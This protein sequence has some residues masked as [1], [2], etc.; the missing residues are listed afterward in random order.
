M[1]RAQRTQRNLRVLDSCG[2]QAWVCTPGQTP[3]W[4]A[5]G[6]LFQ[7]PRGGPGSHTLALKGCLWSLL[8]R[9]KGGCRGLLCHGTH[10]AAAHPTARSSGYRIFWSLKVQLLGFRAMFIAA[11]LRFF[12]FL[13]GGSLTMPGRLLAIG[14]GPSISGQGPQGQVWGQMPSPAGWASS[15]SLQAPPPSIAVFTPGFWQKVKLH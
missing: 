13:T 1:L 12:P 5:P 11:V 10:P 9:P 14:F 7:Q 6:P 4:L 2:I 8:P 3:A 15:S